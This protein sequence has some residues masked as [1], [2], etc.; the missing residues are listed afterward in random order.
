MINI[1]IAD[2]HAVVRKGL[3]QILSEIPDM[4]IGGEASDGDEVLGMV[5]PGATNVII[6][7]ITMPGRSGL[8]VLRDLK[9]EYPEIP[10]LV[11]SMHPEE[12]FARR[13]L[14]EGASGYMNKETAPEDLVQAVRKVHSGG[15]YVSERFAE[16]L[17]F[18]LRG[19]APLATHESLSIREYQVLCMMGSGK[20]VSQIAANLSLT[21]KTISTYRSRLLE[22]M[23]MQNNAEM[24]RY[25]IDNQL[26]V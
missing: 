3:T 23:G 16:E 12:Q 22:K 13:L 5:Q 6:L 17:A 21:V 8:E 24:I 20:T 25:V 10:V 9:R 11:L 14:R 26:F 15:R 19:G 7:D 1:L 18:S 4:V 2:D